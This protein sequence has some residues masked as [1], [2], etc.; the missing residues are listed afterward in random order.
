M[1]VAMITETYEVIEEVS[2]PSPVSKL[3][4][5]DAA[6]ISDDVRSGAAIAV[7][8][9]QFITTERVVVIYDDGRAFAWDQRIK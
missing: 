7:R 1:S 6:Q 5:F 2:P 3:T 9:E 8:G 4:C